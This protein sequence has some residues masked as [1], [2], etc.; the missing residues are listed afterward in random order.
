MFAG[1][2]ATQSRVFVDQRARAAF[3]Y[4]APSGLGVLILHATDESRHVLCPAGRSLCSRGL[5]PLLGLSRTYATRATARAALTLSHTGHTQGQQHVGHDRK[6]GS[7]RSF[8]LVKMDWFYVIST[9]R[10]G[11]SVNT[12]RLA[13]AYL[14]HHSARHNTGHI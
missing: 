13:L 14:V 4:Q 3:R 7:H 1:Q 12:F 11:L 6:E 8:S 2:D 10:S 9:I 5:P